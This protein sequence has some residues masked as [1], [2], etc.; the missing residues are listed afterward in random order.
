MQ[1]YRNAFDSTWWVLMS[2]SV[3]ESLIWTIVKSIKSS[4]TLQWLKICVH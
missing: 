2:T 3:N 4:R 1:V